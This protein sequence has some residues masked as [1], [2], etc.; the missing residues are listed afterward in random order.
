MGADQTLSARVVYFRNPPMA[1][2]ARFTPGTTRTPTTPKNPLRA[3][4]L[5]C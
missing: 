4:A 1:R 3:A 2:I 5:P